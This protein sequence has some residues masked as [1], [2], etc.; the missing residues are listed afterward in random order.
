M[1]FSTVTG[2]QLS[3]PQQQIWQRQ[4]EL[5]EMALAAQ[6]SL[7]LQGNLDPARL[8]AALQAGVEPFEIFRTTF[9]QT[10]GLKRPLQ[11]I[12][13]PGEMVWQVVDLTSAAKTTQTEA[14]AAFQA[15]EQLQIQV[16]K[17]PC[18]R[19][20]LFKQA[21]QTYTLLLT[22]PAL[23]ADAPTYTLLLRQLCQH[24]AGTAMPVEDEPVQYTQ[25]ATWQ[26]QLLSEPDQEAQAFWQ[27][28]AQSPSLP[29]LPPLRDRGLS[30]LDFAPQVQR[31]RLAPDVACALQQMEATTETILLTSWLILLWRQSEQA[32]FSIAVACDGRLDEDLAQICGPLTRSLPL[33]AHLETNMTFL[34]LLRQVAQT[35]EDL[36]DW[37]D[38]YP[39]EP[40]TLLA[41]PPTGFEWV[42]RP[43]AITAAGVEFTLEHLWIYGE[44]PSLR[45]SVVQQETDLTLEFHYDEAEMSAAAIAALSQ[46]LQS[47]LA[48][49]S[50]RP[51]AAIGRLSLIGSADEARIHSEATPP[52]AADECL[53]QRF[54]RQVERTPQATA[55]VFEAASLT[56]EELNR[57]ANQLAHYLQQLGAGPDVPVAVYLE[58]SPEL[59]VALLAV[60]KAGSP[61]LPLDPALPLSGVN[62]RLQDARSPILVTRRS[63]LGETAIAAPQ[64]VCIEADGGTLAQQSPANPVSATAAANLAYVIYTSGS[65]GQPKGVAIEHRQLLSY[66]DSL[67]ERLELPAIAHYAV[68][69]TLAADLGHTMVFPCLCRGGTLHLIAAERAADAQA[70]ADYVQERPI[71]CLKIVPSHLNALLQTPAGEKALPRQRLIVGGEI[72]P[73]SLVEQIQAAAPGCQ[74]F[75]H[76]GPTETTVGAL[77]YAVTANASTPSATV[78]IG[79]AIANSQ[80]YLLDAHLRPVPVGLPGEVYIGGQGVARGYLNRPA[81]TAARFLPNPFSTQPGDRLYRTGDIARRLPDGHLEFL[82]R[83]D[84]QV[85]LHGFRIELGEIEAQLRQHPALQA[86]TVALCQDEPDNPLLVAYGVLLPEATL[87]L[88]DL[89][90]FLQPRLPNYMI[91][92]LLISL[93]ALPLTPNGKI[94]RQALPVPEKIRPE[95]AKQYVA[96]R[97]PTEEAIAAIWADVLGLETVGVHDDFFELGGHSLLATQILSRLRETFEVELPLRQ[98]FEAHTIAAIAAVVEAALLAEIESMTDE[99]AQ[100]LIQ[101]T[102]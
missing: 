89:R 40:D 80:V 42:Q 30:R 4:S 90:Q 11:V 33:V 69:S 78:P 92:S 85:K 51:T 70:L 61:Y 91:P 32:D 37:Q 38:Y 47:L 87:S 60:L 84:L 86:V 2:F 57:Q 26:A 71:D 100:A 66:V 28:Q 29:L 34:A 74:L 17:Q 73:W 3:M 45:L 22:L 94:D 19:A 83:A 64:I 75:N 68:V 23:C 88:S 59:V 15:A 56:Y 24:Y 13:S 21:A 1:S 67:V 95:L 8:Q 46:Q 43:A 53:P 98:L 36:T 97:N 96:P 101:H 5:N 79:Q 62:F 50:Q 72:C 31:T 18:L 81:L 82:R 44:R 54:E 39:I 58:R 93:P 55:L 9:Q 14:V 49:I 99:E 48:D 41:L 16:S 27:Q 10:P 7:S 35:W 12:Q 6:C 52:L 20:G 65:T 63:R 77:T 76:Y 25:F 102:P